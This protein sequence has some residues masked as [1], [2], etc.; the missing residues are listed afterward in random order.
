MI[1]PTLQPPPDPDLTKGIESLAGEL[2]DDPQAW[3]DAPHPMFGG[4]SPRKLIE[5]EPAG[6]KIIRG[7]LMGLKH[8]FAP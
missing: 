5:Q 1:Q 6:E 8:G 7:L 3:L 2:F 4:D